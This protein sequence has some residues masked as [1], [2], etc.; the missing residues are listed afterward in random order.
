MPASTVA[1]A[2]AAVDPIRQVLGGLRHQILPNLTL[3]TH[4]QADL[5][6]M[7]EY[8]SIDRARYRLKKIMVTLF[9]DER[10]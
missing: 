9:W 6:K 2:L 10:R 8:L 4:S 3:S 7:I 5:A 1:Q